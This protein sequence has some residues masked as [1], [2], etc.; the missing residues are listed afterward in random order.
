MDLVI[1]I[2]LLVAQTSVGWARVALFVLALVVFALGVALGAFWVAT[3]LWRGYRG[4]ARRLLA[5][6]LARG[7]IAAE[8]YSQRLRV[9]DRSAESDR[10]MAGLAVMLMIIGIGGSVLVA[11]PILNW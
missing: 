10:R 8:E 4:P 3:R 9:L 7:D 1:S 2:G 6:R 11:S 5:E